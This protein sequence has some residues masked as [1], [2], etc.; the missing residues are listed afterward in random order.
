MQVKF[1]IESGKFSPNT[2][3]FGLE[4]LGCGMLLVCTCWGPTSME[5]NCVSSYTFQICYFIFVQEVVRGLQLNW[6]LV[7]S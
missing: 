5:E 3:I 7:A 4:E 2:H 6:S 1:K